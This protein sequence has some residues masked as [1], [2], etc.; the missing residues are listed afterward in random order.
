MRELQRKQKIKQR[1]YSTPA[2]AVFAI[3]SLILMKGA[4]GVLL[5]AHQSSNDVVALE[6]KAVELTQQEERL[7]GEIHKLT[8]TAGIDEEIKQK[9][10]VS[11][12]G[13]HV[14]VIVDPE[15]DNN[16][17]ASTTRHW[18]RR[19]WDGILSAI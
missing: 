6:I 19:I 17:T 10:N 13:E 16:T 15:V 11:A 14:A 8:T 9:F 12:Q 1:L 4:A 2:L 5:K 18:Y 7:T 3:L